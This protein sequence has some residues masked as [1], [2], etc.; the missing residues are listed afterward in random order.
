[1][2]ADRT[3]LLLTAVC[4]SGCGGL[5]PYSSLVNPATERPE[6]SADTPQDT[7]VDDSN[8]T[9]NVSAVVPSIDSVSPSFG[10]NGGGQT[11][12]IEGSDFPASFDLTFGGVPADVVSASDN[13]LEVIIPQTTN[14]GWV[15]V[16]MFAAAGTGRLTDGYQFWTDGTDLTGGIVTLERIRWVGNY[17]ESTP[18]PSTWATL[19]FFRPMAFEYWENYTETYGGCSSNYYWNAGFDFYEPGAPSINLS[20]PSGDIPLT[21][22]TDEAGAYASTYLDAGQFTESAEY[23]IDGIQG[24]QNWPNFEVPPL[25]AGSGSIGIT[26][27][28]VN[29]NTAPL[30]NSS[31]ELAWNGASADYVIIFLAHFST[32]FTATSYEVAQTVS[33]VVP[34]TGSFQIP[35]TAWQTWRLDPTDY[36]LLEVGRVTETPTIL[37][38]DNSTAKMVSVSW[39]VG[40]MDM[41]AN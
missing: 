23:V 39:T 41:R 14:I 10:S 5:A 26:S 12:V 29:Q 9:S 34:D 37:P 36:L 19:S 25:T 17:W 32:V 22:S 24:D 3:L 13:R 6:I 15:D 35:A 33:C 1:M 40:A 2:A 30:V 38:H 20:G 27:P 31:F 28:S 11:V 8:N 7:S 18:N 16:E 4:L 21:P